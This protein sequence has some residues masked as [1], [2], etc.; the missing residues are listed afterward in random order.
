MALCVA[1]LVDQKLLSYDDLI[2]KHWPDFGNNG[3][4]NITVQMLL[5]HTAGL[6]YLEERIS[7]NNATNYINMRKVFEDEKPKWSAGQKL[8]YHAYT[9]YWL[10]DQ[11]VR[12]VDLQKRG[13]RQFFNEEIAIKF[14]IIRMPSWSNILSELYQR[15]S[16]IKTIP[17]NLLYKDSLIYKVASSLK[18]L[19]PT[20]PMQVNNRNFYRLLCFGF[21]NAR[22]LAKTFHVLLTKKVVSTETQFLISK[23]IVNSTDNCFMERF[24]R[25]N[26]FMYFDIKQREE[27]WYAYGHSGFG[28]QQVLHD[29][30]NDLT[31]AYVTNAIK[32]GTYKNCRT[33]S[34]LQ[35]IIY[36]VVRKY[37][38]SY[39]L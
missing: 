30:R 28:C 17:F 16:L 6:P 24:A 27:M 14:G 10:V 1:L 2:T 25:G 3:K 7:L 22:S 26:G 8:G 34:R 5:S 4:A 37:N 23:V 12:H 18:W 20:K 19:H 29:F 15:P 13:I 33:Y 38:K 35:N 31:I 39:P 9:F 36:K 32:I 21:G 11:I